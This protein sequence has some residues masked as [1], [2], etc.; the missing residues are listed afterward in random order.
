VSHSTKEIGLKVQNT[1]SSSGVI[2]LLDTFLVFG[3]KDCTLLEH[4]LPM[5]IESNV[6]SRVH[7]IGVN[8]FCVGGEV[9][10][11]R[12]T[13]SYDSIGTKEF[14]VV[15][16]FSTEEGSEFFVM[17]RIVSYSISHCS[18]FNLILTA[19]ESGR[20]VDG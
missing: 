12:L 8:K 11:R 7:F 19:L 9:V 6:P 17:K 13:C 3:S 4:D 10:E 20:R 14:I 16:K 2:T 1:S 18:N 15:F 5:E